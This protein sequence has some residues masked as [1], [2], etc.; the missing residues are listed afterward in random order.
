MVLRMLCATVHRK[1]L[2]RG[3]TNFS[4]DRT[5]EIVY[6]VLK[7]AKIGGLAARDRISKMVKGL[8]LDK[9][10]SVEVRTLFFTILH[11]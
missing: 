6:F 8:G 2:R 7:K 3:G 10:L 9:T 4:A 1:S 5:I 11:T